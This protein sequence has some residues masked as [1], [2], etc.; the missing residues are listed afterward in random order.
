VVTKD[1]VQQFRKVYQ[2][3]VGDNSMTTVFNR[4]HRLKSLQGWTWDH[5]LSEIDKIHPGGIDEKTLYSHYRQPHKKPTTHVSKLINQLHALN[6]PD[7]FPQ[8]INCLMS[9]YNNLVGCKKHLTRD[10]DIEDLQFFLS[11]QL[12]R[13][14]EQDQLRIARLAWL[15]GNIH[16]DRI[17]TL[18]DNGQRHQLNETRQLA[19]DYYQTS[20]TAIENHNQKSDEPVGASYLY[21]AR[22]NILACYLNA[23]LQEHRSSDPDV[24][25]YLRQ[26]NYIPESKSTIQAEPFQWSIARNGLRFS[27]LLQNDEDVRYFFSALVNVSDKFLDLDYQP[28]NYG[29]IAAGVDFQWAVKQVLTPEYIRAC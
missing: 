18:R 11:A 10:R 7:P 24:L 23:V 5:F 13:E 4:V 16:F 1:D 12:E 28:L 26:S 2:G 8:D 22:H 27:S 9:V 29:S 19:I 20:V 14:N 25:K 3:D 17:P 15:L 6:F 21:K